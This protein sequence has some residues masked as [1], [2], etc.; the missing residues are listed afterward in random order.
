MRMTLPWTAGM[1]PKERSF[2]GR[3]G[4]RVTQHQPGLSIPIGAEEKEIESP[5][6]L[7]LKSPSYDATVVSAPTRC[8]RVLG[9]HVSQKVRHSST[10]DREPA[11]ETYLQATAG[12]QRHFKLVK[13]SLLVLLSARRRLNSWA[14]EVDR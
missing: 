9:L 5:L 3:R 12:S 13:L 8:A 11:P 1:R 7:P 14:A 2:A 10:C 4:E 6:T